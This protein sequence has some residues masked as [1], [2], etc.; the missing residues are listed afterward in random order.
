MKLPQTKKEWEDHISSLQEKEVAL[1]LSKDEIID[2]LVLRVEKTIVGMAQ[3]AKGRIGVLFSGGI[4][5]TLI[6]FVL[7]KNNIPFVCATVGFKDSDAQK[8][9]ED[10]TNA[11]VIAQEFG[12]EYSE[13]VFS[14]S[15][16]H[17]IFKELTGIFKQEL[18]NAV[19]MGVGSVELVGVRLLKEHGCSDIFGGLGSE[20]LYAGY[21]RHSDAKDKHV[22]CWNGLF[23]MFERDLLRDFAIAKH[24]NVTFWVPFLDS[25]IIS[26]SMNIPIDYKINDE[27]SKII[28]RE[29]A[30]QLGLPKKYSFRPKRAAQYGSR[31]DS[32]LAKCAKKKG[33]K[34]K[35]EYIFSLMEN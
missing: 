12:F 13:R 28:I 25:D 4:D 16:M 24:E 33:F 8:E 35:K 31:T 29:A 22:E 9:P 7:Q 21:K 34:Y 6:A 11:R 23:Q 3:Q 14:L 32:A 27:M 19:N 30:L 20:E 5:S 18:S 26:F 10:I 15:D 2:E 1:T 17:T